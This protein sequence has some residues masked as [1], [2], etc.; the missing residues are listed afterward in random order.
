MLGE[1]WL[2]VEV[3]AAEVHSESNRSRL[4]FGEVPKAPPSAAGEFIESCPC[5]CLLAPVAEGDRADGA[6][7][8]EVLTKGCQASPMLASARSESA[9]RI[10]T[11]RSTMRALSCPVHTVRNYAEERARCSS[12]PCSF[13]STRLLLRG[14]G[15][16]CRL[17]EQASLAPPRHDGLAGP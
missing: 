6:K 10:V 17:L 7:G 11:P 8:T 4:G 1:W 16:L 9:E 15:R 13:Q 14:S 5:P 3:V 2:T 12:L